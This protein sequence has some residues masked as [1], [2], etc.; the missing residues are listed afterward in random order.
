MQCRKQ[1]KFLEKRPV[2]IT[3]VLE[4]RLAPVHWNRIIAAARQRRR[5]FSTL[6]RYCVLRLARKCSLRWTPRLQ[7]AAQEVKEGV[8]AASSLHRHMMC[9]YGDDEK[10]IRLAAMD[11]GITMTAFARL[12]I[13]LY[14]RAVA[15]ENRSHRMVSDLTLTWEGIRFTETI[16]IFAENGG[17]WPFLRNLSCLRFELESYW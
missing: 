1:P 11:L 14:L 13:E 10:L 12:A 16:Q 5:T 2:Q 3:Q 9:L 6:T 15:M 17:G 7:Q 4:I 8:Q